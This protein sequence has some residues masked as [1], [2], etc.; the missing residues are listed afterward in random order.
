MHNMTIL[1]RRIKSSPVESSHQWNG[2][3]G[4]SGLKNQSQSV[5]FPFYR[6]SLY[7]LAASRPVSDDCVPSSLPGDPFFKLLFFF[8]FFFSRIF[9]FFFTTWGK[10]ARLRLAT[11][12]TTVYYPSCWMLK[13][14]KWIFL[15]LASLMHLLV[16]VHPISPL[17]YATRI[18]AWNEEHT[19]FPL[20]KIL[21]LSYI[22]EIRYFNRLNFIVKNS[23]IRFEPKTLDTFILKFKE[24]VRRKK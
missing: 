23:C 10:R 3:G 4:R 20:L 8:V 1:H 22:N 24:K 6:N 2:A 21:I 9:S 16:Y 13:L 5:S 11:L 17:C 7:I 18:E 15:L 19:D 14:L 12:K